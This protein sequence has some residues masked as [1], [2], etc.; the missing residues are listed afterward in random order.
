[1]YIV[2]LIF[3]IFAQ[4][5]NPLVNSIVPAIAFVLSTLTLSFCQE[6][7][8][9]DGWHD[10]ATLRVVLEHAQNSTSGSNHS[11]QTSGI[12]T[13]KEMWLKFKKTKK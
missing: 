2:I 8:I 1:T 3:F 4:L 5:P 10:N 9:T 6:P 13:F 12:L 7:P 11:L